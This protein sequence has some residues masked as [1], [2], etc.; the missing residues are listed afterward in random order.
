MI[1]N[2]DISRMSRMSKIVD[3][4]IYLDTDSLYDPLRNTLRKSA[5]GNTMRV[6]NLDMRQSRIARN[7]R[8]LSPL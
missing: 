6:Q 8:S 4:N 7:M 1:S 5:I 2:N 3:H